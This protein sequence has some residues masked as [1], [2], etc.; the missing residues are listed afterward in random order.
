MSQAPGNGASPVADLSFEFF[1]PKSEAQD[2]ALAAT[3]AQLRQLRPSYVSVTYGAGGS[4]QQRSLGTVERIHQQGVPVAAHLTC[5]GASAASLGETIGWFRAR[6]IARFVA[7]RGDSPGGMSE[8]YVPHSDGYSD[9]A[10]LVAA[11][12][13]AGAEDVAVSAYPE[14]HP[15]SPDWVH[16]IAVLKRKVE[17]G[18]DR[19]I[20]QFFFDNDSF[21]AY[22]ERVRAAGIDV[23]IVPGI[24]PIHRFTAIRDFASR[25]GASIPQRLSARFDGLEADGDEHVAAA[26]EVATAQI[27]DLLRR[28][29][30]AFHLY[31]LNRGD[32]TSAVC[33]AAGLAPAQ[34]A[35]DGR[36]GDA[37]SVAA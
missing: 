9:T 37:A 4:S 22:V 10:H 6:G 2:A 27:A 11:L 13:R 28:G 17:A 31:T 19:A 1:P 3:V 5:A 36:G 26:I 18:A 20:T 33:R 29:V 24:I 25:C 32:L 12:K 21:E 35:V 8:P 23:P 15:Q 34:N 16:E 7:L 14:R 30:S